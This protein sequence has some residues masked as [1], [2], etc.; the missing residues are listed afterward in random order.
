MRILA[1]LTLVIVLCA[2]AAVA[3]LLQSPVPAADWVSNPVAS[4]KLARGENP[5]PVQ[6]VLP[7]P[8]PLSAMA[9]LGKQIFFDP[10]LSASSRLSCA[11][12]HSPENHFG[13]AGDAPVMLGGP[14]LASQ[15]ARA[16]PSLEYLATQPN[17]S[18]GPDPGGDDEAPVPLP[19]LAARGAAAKRVTKTA[20]DT[21]QS[22]ANLVPL[23]GL[24]WDGRANT[25]QLQAMGP[26][27]SPFEM[28]G[29]SIARIAA[30]LQ[31]APY[32][33]GMVQ[34]FGPTIFQT[35]K[36]AVS[37]ALFA[38][39]RYQL[40]DPGFHPYNSKYD[41]WLQ[42]HARLSA[43]EMRGYE[44][45][46]DPAKGDCAACHLD[47]PT[48]DHQPPLFT[49]HQFEALGLPRN[50]L[51]VFNNNPKYYDLGICGPYRT[52]LAAQT[53][54]CGMF[55]TPTLRNAATRQVFFH[56]G[57]YHDL[58]HVL[59][60]YNF[61]V[62]QP[63]QIYPRAADGQVEIFNDLPK[64][65]WKNIDRSDPPFD[66]QAGD[67]PPL[68]PAEEQDIIAFLKTLTDGYGQ[69]PVVLASAGNAAVP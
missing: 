39:A 6:L 52:D 62:A 13:P 8:Q 64:R 16:V 51:I 69:P 7:Q 43:A 66:K 45:F 24:F 56:N 63:Q 25:L 59:D 26:L 18:I 27:L 10:S 29:G 57:V 35:P 9:L 11:S 53:Q 38:V 65:Y 32:A 33:G 54:Y 50:P 12:C 15:G 17:F 67:K 60:F 1:G 2:S 4:F 34:L 19:Q 28:D 23:G 20:Q 21:A 49:D 14:N 68:S 5:A 22:A 30:K 47:Q 58:K 3:A 61:S 36:L 48:V 55:L 41:A 37:E 42:G 31:A 40:E 46:N 44:L